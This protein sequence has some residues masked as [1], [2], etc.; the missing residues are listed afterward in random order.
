M[1]MKMRENL[2]VVL[3]ALV[4]MFILTIFLEWGAGGADILSDKNLAGRIGDRKISLAEFDQIYRQQAAQYKQNSGQEIPEDQA[5]LFRKQV[6]TQLVND[7][8]LSQ[9]LENLGIALTDSEFVYGTYTDPIPQFK[10]NQ[11]FQE[12]GEFSSDK[13]RQFISQNPGMAYQLQNYYRVTFPQ[14]AMQLFVDKASHISE[15]EILETYKEENLKAKVQFFGV[16]KFR[17][18]AS[19]FNVTD[20]EIETYYKAN[21]DDFKTD[22]KRKVEYVRIDIKPT[23][24]DTAIVLTELEELKTRLANGGDFA[25]E[26]RFMSEDKASAENNGEVDFFTKETYSK[27]FDEI[28]FNASKD[29][30]VGPIWDNNS[31]KIV[32]IIDKR[33]N[34]ETKKDEVK[35]QQIVKYV[36][37][38]ATTAQ[39]Y[40]AIAEEARAIALDAGDLKTFA[41]DKDVYYSETGYFT[42]NGF[43]PGIGRN[44]QLGSFI[45]SKNIGSVSNE[46]RRNKGQTIFL[47]K[48]LDIKESGYESLETVKGRIKNLVMNEKRSEKAKEVLASYKDKLATMTFEEVAKLDTTNAVIT[49]TTDL[50]KSYGSFFGKMGKSA[51]IAHA[52]NTLELHALSDILSSSVGSF[53]IKVEERAAFNEEDYLAKKEEI[54]TRL[55][56]QKG[57]NLY[58]QWLTDAKKKYNVEEYRLY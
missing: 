55:E 7:Y 40:D 41:E 45:F 42:D 24:E 44:L 37:V 49:E 18:N 10:S 31:F 48:I 12:N 19:L 46:I 11:Q 25:E 14:K 13:L 6:W 34:S 47:V 28:V 8:V 22:E 4:F 5:D 35:I 57:Y 3:Y 54:R 15:A 30:I 16:N 56:N 50:A 1:M 32:K 20:K 17:L 27:Q 51:E 21:K 38:G 9:E 52:V 26:A 43:I 36:S 58:S 2:H 39:N 29:E 53:I 33:K 23:K